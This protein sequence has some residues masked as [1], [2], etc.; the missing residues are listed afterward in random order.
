MTHQRNHALWMLEKKRKSLTT[1]HRAIMK[2]GN[3]VNP[4]NL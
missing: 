4:Q 3:L 2:L 1:N